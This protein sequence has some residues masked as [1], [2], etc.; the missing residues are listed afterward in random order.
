MTTSQVDCHVAAGPASPIHRV[1]LRLDG[2]V[3]GV[4]LRPHVSRLASR[5]GLN[6]WVANTADGVTVE[7]E[8]DGRAVEDFARRLIGELP[9]LA[10][11]D[12]L[13]REDLPGTGYSVFTIRD[14]K[15]EGAGK[16]LVLPDVATCDECLAEIV[17]PSN[18]RFGYAFTNCTNC[19]PRYSILEALPYDRANTTMRGFAMCSA[20]RAEYEDPSDRRY[21]A[22]PNACP[23][24]GPRLVLLDATGVILAAHDQALSAAK[25][26][27]RDGKI[28]AVKGLG[29]F[30][31]LA[32]ARDDQAVA[33]LRRRKARPAKPFAVMAP[34]LRFVEIHLQVS[35]LERR[36]LTS[37]AA[38]IVLLRRRSR[39][40]RT[41][42]ALAQ[43]IAPNNPFIGIMLP[44]TPLHHLLMRAVGFPV[45]ATSGNISD[46]PMVTDEDEAIERLAGIADLFLVH[47]RPI[48]SPLD[49][50]VVRVV[51]GRGLMLRRARGYAPLSLPLARPA[52]A[53]LALGGH[54]K[55]AI[56][57]T[58]GSRVIV[59]PHVGD[60]DSAPARQA[61]KGSVR[62]L[63]EMHSVEPMA[64]VCDRHPDYHTTRI[65][66]ST[67]KKVIKVQHHVAHIAACMADNV[68]DGPVLGIAWDGTGYGDD[69]TIW[70]GEFMLVDGSSAR[71]VGHLRHFPLAGGE[72]AVTEPRRAAVGLLY[73]LEGEAVFVDP[74]LK[75]LLTFSMRERKVLARMLSKHI[76]APRTSSVGRLFDAVASLLGLAQRTSFEGEA[77]MAVEFALDSSP[78]RSRYILEMIPWEG[79]KDLAFAL[80]WTP[81]LR[82]LIS[83]IR[84]GVS[85]AE[86]AAAFHGAL[87]DAIVAVARRV[88]QRRVVLT[89]GCFQNGAL[90]GGA[91]ERLRQDGFEPYWHQHVPPNDG[92]LA[93]GQ[94]VWAA[95]LLDS[96]KT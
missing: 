80:D 39:A 36:L 60:L 53:L 6:G 73:E 86:V 1:R 54:M 17:D 40:G 92:G 81:M 78:P 20:C 57:V 34:S 23:D 90:T 49:D 83:D 14:S 44:Y 69:G 67:E 91:V 24:C 28:V 46:E 3:Q 95:R 38:P 79:A 4:G 45:V 21:H 56:A 94:A 84:S 64:I 89:G 76:N 85:V 16:A 7:V 37:P 47:D 50:S 29:G 62:R 43:S 77:A 26:A 55:S 59:G 12:R 33:E 63:R 5:L 96:E 15:C 2:M 48:A 18:R 82:A 32:D 42:L 93:L 22:Q 72:V 66:A 65:A 88:G 51:A 61:F 25:S 71:R 9:P 74:T 87:I 58:T 10:R 41:R 68:I 8:G 11:V 52:P 27:L 35:A 19:G 75:P 31:L 13:H 30:Q 70:G